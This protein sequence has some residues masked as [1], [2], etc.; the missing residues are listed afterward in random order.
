MGNEQ[1]MVFK[2]DSA[3]TRVDE[4]IFMDESKV[5][6]QREIGFYLGAAESH[7]RKDKGRTLRTLDDYYKM[8]RDGLYGS[9]LNDTYSLAYFRAFL[10]ML[11]NF[12]QVFRTMHGE[13]PSHLINE[14][15][16]TG[17]VKIEG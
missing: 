13:P 14:D 2:K 15:L 8:V 9:P 11:V 10:E 4:V 5:A 12:I 6:L 17:W 7:Y 3:G 1:Y 16:K